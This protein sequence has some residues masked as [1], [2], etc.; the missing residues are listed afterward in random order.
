MLISSTRI[1]P[2]TSRSCAR[3]PSA[4]S[5]FDRNIAHGGDDELAW[6]SAVA[7][8]YNHFRAGLARIAWLHRQIEPAPALTRHARFQGEPARSFPTSTP[9]EAS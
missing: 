1:A 9:A 3:G 2:G 6:A 4:L 8:K 5:D 7:L